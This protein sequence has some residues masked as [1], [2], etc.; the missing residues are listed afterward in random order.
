MGVVFNL[1]TQDKTMTQKQADDS[2]LSF[3]Q[4]NF[5]VSGHKNLVKR[6]SRGRTPTGDPN[7]VD[8]YIGSRIKLRRQALALSQEKLADLMGTTFQQVQ[9]YERGANRV[10]GSRMWDLC[11]ILDVEPS[12]F[13]AEMPKK[14]RE[15]SPRFQYLNPI[16]LH[17]GENDILTAVEDPMM[18]A[19]SI[20]LVTAYE[21]I[22]NRKLAKS[23]FNAVVNA[24]YTVEPQEE[25]V[26]DDDLDDAV[27]ESL[28]AIKFKQVKPVRKKAEQ[29]REEVQSPK[30][31]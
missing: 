24:S 31:E 21:K 18:K 8:V 12:Y 5:A 19:E 29:P 15:G 13:Y 23:L 6:S 26:G 7:P 17:E 22:P 11:C 25:V 1:V 4:D 28:Q 16:R 20:I 27:I 9:K 2:G 3:I 14:R 30:D 10:S